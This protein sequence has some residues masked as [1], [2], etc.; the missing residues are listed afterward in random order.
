MRPETIELI[1]SLIALG[2]GLPDDATAEERATYDYTLS[3]RRKKLNRLQREL[4]SKDRGETEG[5]TE[6]GERVQKQ[7]APKRRSRTQ[8]MPPAVMGETRRDLAP[9]LDSHDTAP[10]PTINIV[11]K[12]PQECLLQA[13][14]YLMSIKPT[15][16]DPRLGL[17]NDILKSLT[18]TREE[19]SQKENTQ[20]KVTA[21]APRAPR[22]SRYDEELKEPAREMEAKMT[23]KSRLEEDPEEADREA[24][25]RTQRS[26]YEDDPK[27]MSSKITQNKVGKS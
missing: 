24:A 22:A 8:D 2:V 19:L 1:N 12:T 13:Q 3:Q 16:G 4:D 21:A 17:H 6:T 10:D 23:Q 15:V 25:K 27:D 20:V 5:G 9:A 7:P 11:P 18:Q 26:S 14:T